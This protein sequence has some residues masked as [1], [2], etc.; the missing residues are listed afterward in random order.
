MPLLN[1]FAAPFPCRRTGR[2]PALARQAAARETPMHRLAHFLKRILSKICELGC[3]IPPKETYG[4]RYANYVQRLRAG[5]YLQLCRSTVFPGTRL[6]DTKALQALSPGKEGRSGGIRPPFGSFTGN[7]CDLLGLRSAHYR[8]FRA[9]RRSAGL[10][11]RLLHGA[12][13]KRRRFQRPRPLIRKVPGSGDLLSSRALTVQDFQ[14][15][16]SR[17]SRFGRASRKGSVESERTS[18]F[19]GRHF[20]IAVST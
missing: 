9:A 5:L 6:L 4:R 16:A 14:G 11:P 19:P 13:G 8:S 20:R 12:Q 7:P 18:A 10:L 1:F 2:P 17:R 3:T 15:K